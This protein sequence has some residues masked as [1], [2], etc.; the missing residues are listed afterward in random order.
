MLA[1]PTSGR[2]QGCP[3]LLLPRRPCRQSTQASPPA[4]PSAALH[5][6]PATISYTEHF[7]PSE[8]DQFCD[9]DR[10]HTKQFSDTEKEHKEQVTKHNT[11]ILINGCT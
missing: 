9:G 4:E 5:A 3:S 10:E 6:K 8:P 2:H 11:Q 1:P 7:S